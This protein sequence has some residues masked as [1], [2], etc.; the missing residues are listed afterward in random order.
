[1]LDS[2][3]EDE[4]QLCS[5]FNGHPLLDEGEKHVE[6][7]NTNHDRWPAIECKPGSRSEAQQSELFALVG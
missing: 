3:L 7:E 5:H 1:M 2:G 6:K 4:G